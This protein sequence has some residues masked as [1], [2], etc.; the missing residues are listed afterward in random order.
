MEH[1][2]LAEKLSSN[3][4]DC[5]KRIDEC[6]EWV[7]HCDM[8]VTRRSYQISAAIKKRRRV[9]FLKDNKRNSSRVG[10]EN[11]IQR[12]FSAMGWCLL[13]MVTGMGPTEDIQNRGLVTWLREKT[14]EDDATNL[15]LEMMIDPNLEGK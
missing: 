15:W 8:A 1:G 13:K 2:T 3:V 12:K 4:L 5:E 6:L 9:K 7:L 14:T 11:H 10:F